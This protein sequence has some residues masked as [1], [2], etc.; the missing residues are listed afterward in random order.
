MVVLR[1]L[2]Y[3]KTSVVELTVAVT[4]VGISPSST[5]FLFE[6][7]E[8]DSLGAGSVSTAVLLAAST[9]VPSLSVKELSET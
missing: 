7:S 1:A 2:S 8:L 5:M 3:R 9:I 6:P 4:S